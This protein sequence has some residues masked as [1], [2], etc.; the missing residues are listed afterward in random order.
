MKET[1]KKVFSLG[2]PLL[3]I[4][5]VF[6]YFSNILDFGFTLLDAVSCLF[7]GFVIAY[8]LNLFMSKFEKLYFPNS[9]NKKVNASRRPV[10]ILLSIVLVIFI[11]TLVLV[12]ILPKLGETIA[13]LTA[14]I[15]KAIDNLIDFLTKTSEKYPVLETYLNDFLQEL[16]FAKI[17]RELTNYFGNLSKDFLS[18]TTAMLGSIV[19]VVANFV[20]S[21]IF[22]LYLL[23]GKEKLISQVKYVCS[24]F[25]PQRAYKTILH[26]ISVV[27]GTFSNYI[28]GQC[29]EALILGALCTLGMLIFRF[30][31]APMVGAVVG[32][33]AL[34]PVVGAYIGAGVGVF[35]IIMVSPIKAVFFLIFIL[36]LQQLENNLIYPK[37]VG[38]SIGLPGIWV[39]AAVTVSGSLIGVF[40]I[41]LG[42]PVTAILYQLLKEY[43]EYK[44]AQL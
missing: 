6:R 9:K 19:S 5:L 25:L 23:I 29:T 32:A 41:L 35:L 12:L 4:A 31:Y 11:I 27:N 8:V 14:T 30:P 18:T 10:C 1:S 21:L 16:D 15:P 38:S 39:L 37:V 34:L 20:I 22:A 13:M 2:I 26:I 40:G 3:I 33:T 36:I 43:T 7:T 28:I 17:A 24:V 42:V 44:K